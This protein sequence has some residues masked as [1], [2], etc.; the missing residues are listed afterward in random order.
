MFNFVIW[1]PFCFQPPFF[2]CQKQ[3]FQRANMNYHAKSGS[4]SLKIGRVM[5]LIDFSKI[6]P[7]VKNCNT[8][9]NYMQVPLPGST[10]FPPPPLRVFMAPSLTQT[11][12]KLDTTKSACQ[13][14][15]T[16]PTHNTIQNH[17]IPYQTQFIFNWIKIVCP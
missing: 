9:T 15:K 1:W 10:S 6:S 13:Y 16:I 12:F 8:L 4:C 17:T 2:F 5:A 3:I 14:I 11:L 7:L